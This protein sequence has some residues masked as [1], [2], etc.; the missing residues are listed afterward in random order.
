MPRSQNR[1][2]APRLIRPS[3]ARTSLRHPPTRGDVRS[4]NQRPNAK[5]R[6]QG[7]NPRPPSR[8]N[9]PTPPNNP[10]K[11]KNMRA[12]I[13]IAT[14]NMNGL[15]S[16]SHNM[17]HIKKWA[18]VNQTLNKHKI[19]IL[20]LQETHL[21][22]EAIAEIRRSFGRKMHIEYSSDPDAPRANAGVAFVINKS[23]IAPSEIHAHE[24]YP[25]RA[26]ALKIKWLEN[27]S[28]TLLNIYAPVNKAL[29]PPFW[30]D[31]ET[32]RLTR[33]LP[34]PDFM[35]GD[36]NVTEDPI[37]RAP[38]RQDD[39]GAT[40]ALRDIRL[41]WNIQDTWRLSYPDDR[42]FTYRANT[43]GEQTKSRIDR[44]YVA[45]NLTTLTF[46]WKITPSP[47][48]TDHWLTK[49]KFA[50]RD[51]P[52][53]GKGR[54]TLP[55]YLLNNKKFIDAVVEKGIR[56]QSDL[57]NPENIPD[58]PQQL[59]ELFKSDIQEIAKDIIGKSFYKINSR[60]LRL[61][62]DRDDLA[63]DPNADMNDD[64]R[65]SEAIIAEELEHLEKLIA[66]DKRSKL[67]AEL[68]A[69]GE[70]LGGIW[71]A[72]SKEKKPRNLIPRLKIPGT[73]PPQY[74]RDSERMA[75]LVKDYHERLQHDDR[76]LELEDRNERISLIV[77]EIPNEQM[78][79]NDDRAAED[80]PLSEAQTR[81]ALH[82]SKNGTATGMD[83]CPYELWKSLQT[84]HEK[85]SRN[86][87]PS[88]DIIK[89][90]TIIFADIQ[91]NGVD[92]KTGFALGWMCPLYKKKDRTEICNYRPITL[93]NTDYK[94]LT[95]ALA[96]QLMDHLGSLVHKDQAGFIPKRSILD[97]IRLAKAIIN[98]AE[99]SE[100]D[101]AIVALDQEKAYDKIHHDYLWEVLDAFNLP[102]TFTRTIKALYWNASTQVAVNGFLSDPFRITRGIRQGD[103]LSCAIFDLA[104]EP[105]ACII[106]REPNLRGIK[107]PGIRDPLKAKFFADDTSIFMNKL[108]SFESLQMILEDWCIA[109]GAKF[110]IDK[111]EIIP[112]GSP[113]HREQVIRTRKVNPNDR[114]PL[115][116]RIRIAN[117]G[118]AIR[119]LGAW[120]GNHTNDAV[121]W[122]PIVNK[123]NKDLERWGTTYPT[124]KGRKTIVQAVVG[125]CTQY[126]T[127]AQGMPANIEAAITKI[128]RNFM[129]NDDSSPRLALDIL[130][131][132]IKEGGL[133]LLDIRARNEAIEIMWLKAYLNI[134]PTRP[135]W[136]IV[137]D[138][139]ID[140]AAPPATIPKA[141]QNTFLQT[142]HPATRGRRADHMGNDT[143]RM[144]KTA[145]KFNTNL[146]PLRLSTYLRAQLPAWYHLASLQG[147]ITNATAK[148]LLHT[149]HVTKVADLV[150]T[151]AQ[152]RNPEAVPNAPH[153]QIRF[154]YCQ[155]CSKDRA[156]GCQ[157]PNACAAEA[158]T[159]LEQIA[160]K[161]NPLSPGNNHGDLSLTR[162]RKQWN[163]TARAQNGDIL[164]DPSIT[165]KTDLS[166]TFRIFTDPTKISDRP[167]RRCEPRETRLR[168]QE[169]SVY[170]DGAC[171]RNG[172]ANAQS[173]SGVWHGPDHEMNR[174]IRVPG[175]QQSN[176]VGELVAIIAAVEAIPINQP[177][178][179]ITD[180]KYAIEGLT[181]HLGR[182]EDHGWI[183][184]KNADLFKRAAY[185]LKR[186]TARTS[187]R[188]IKGHEGDQGNEGSDQLAKAGANKAT[189]DPLDLSIP[190]EFDL[191]GAKLIT[192]SQSMAYKGIRER[193][194]TYHRRTTAANLQQT[195]VALTDYN[196]EIETDETIW[197]GI[198]HPDVR[199]KVRQF[200]YKAMHG[201]Q[202]I[203]EFWKHIPEY[204][205][206]Q[207]CQTCHTTETM[208]HILVECHESAVNTISDWH[209]SHD[210]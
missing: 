125:G 10:N 175:T 204:E 155:D 11:Q 24:L 28:T 109:S 124:M 209:G 164:F 159:R 123:I 6:P 110:N 91:K 118:D 21:D 156:S 8:E 132:P 69:H 25:G 146:A 31:V 40:D 133:N 82:L 199:I 53:I 33:R 90:L 177:L 4:A 210:P 184:I 43:N 165:C 188:W 196:N 185:L 42:K 197:T 95:K 104:I 41:K 203:G 180:S 139:L 36:L 160:P 64:L 130:Q 50:P 98:Y 115:S 150:R 89:T 29:Q 88:F 169:V 163:V 192:L 195:R 75:D 85:A 102:E 137:T 119:F 105:L 78:M 128:I 59:W 70:K 63:N 16:P 202:K 131:R 73:N 134:S 142:W 14:L 62:K 86:N 126:L 22:E 107:I 162:R 61:E 12:S 152:I 48:P 99:A 93:L 174:A 129:W 65:T 60:I 111:T 5:G 9:A 114:E 206:R 51:A 208:E 20:A 3:G 45:D 127:M 171:F 143:T 183:G 80:H 201:T 154:C 122:E 1:T 30:T 189:T 58:S 144:L 172:K 47:V 103:P 94:I 55:L 79:R 113:N 17:N 178:I 147:P 200:L 120:I 101:G 18:M 44:I 198:Q 35:L 57:E 186:R 117:D 112:I 194:P 108:D 46:D 161:L 148:C 170:T 158:Q 138:L 92:E 167:A 181:S 68:S 19:A 32:N 168:L 136:A 71:S 157:N 37:D 97:H 153:L 135:A 151:S 56:L 84:K 190:A 26:L 173:G 52:K 121:P 66:H 72:I 38:A 100:E 39:L 191:Q 140:T 76:H 145:N 23:L 2:T 149:H 205:E 49:V 83:G 13:N 34:R 15:T 96:I 207:M 193:K 27:E 182:W 106:R 187:F 81:K 54:W 7:T 141:R 67:G 116:E 179:I 166:D 87:Q 77:D 74:E 176:Q